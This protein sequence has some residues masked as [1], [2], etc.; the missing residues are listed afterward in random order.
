[1]PSLFYKGG[2]PRFANWSCCAKRRSNQQFLYDIYPMRYALYPPPCLNWGRE[3]STLPA[4]PQRRG[5]NGQGGK[6]AFLLHSFFVFSS[7][8]W[9]QTAPRTL[10]SLRFQTFLLQIGSHLKQFWMLLA[11]LEA[12]GTPLEPFYP[13][14]DTFN[15]FWSICMEKTSHFVT[16]FFALGEHLFLL[17]GSGT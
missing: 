2:R 1:M 4:F 3:I 13:H 8:G 6:P 14:W 7:C 17:G 11:A 12:S 15:E 16:F 10:L 5:P 9:R